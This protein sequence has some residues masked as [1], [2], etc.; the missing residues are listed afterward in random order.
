MKISSMSITLAIVLSGLMTVAQAS[1][2]NT[3]YVGAKVGYNSNHP[4]STK[5]ADKAYPGVEMG[6]TRDVGK[7]AMGVDVF[8]DW[9][10]KSITSS[11]YGADVKIGYPA[12]KFLPYMKL[13]AAGSQP[14]TRVHG[15]VGLEYK[16]SQHWSMVGEWTGDAKTIN[17]SKHINSN[18][19]FGLNYY[20]D[21][22]VAA[23]V[24]VAPP[25][26]VKAPEPKPEPVVVPPP[27]P[28]PPPPVVVEPEPIVVQPLPNKP[29][30]VDRP[31]T[32][33]GASFD[34]GSARLQPSA[35][36]QLD[37]VV[38]F[39]K[40][41]PTSKLAVMG[42]TDSTGSVQ[43]NQRLSERRAQSVKAYLV[44]KGVD[45]SRISTQGRGSAEPI[46]DNKTRAGRAE[47][48]RVEINSVKR[49]E[50]K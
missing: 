14:G 6:Y 20:F 18:I 42:H 3:G 35:F 11:D 7:F 22:K 38:E 4:S 24:V 15:G 1:E 28:P 40:V 10:D 46:G 8:L 12:G 2:F 49:V 47:N 31:V 30:F 16:L 36:E 45:G 44:W 13:G 37:L 41:N 5:T 25:V 9:H 48:R 19:T 34:T 33:E 26:V 23:P 29:I 32:I 43:T 17:T 39:A 21:M 50:K 27:P